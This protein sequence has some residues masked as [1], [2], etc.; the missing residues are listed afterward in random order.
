FIAGSNVT[1]YTAANATDDV[2]LTITVNDGG[3]NGI[4]GAQEDTTTV[5]LSVTPVNDAPVLADTDVVLVGVIEDAGQPSG[6]VGTLVTDL[7]GG[8]SDVDSDDAKGIAIVGVSDQGTLW[9]STNSSPNGGVWTEV[10]GVSESNALL[11]TANSQTRIYFQPN[12]DFSGTLSDA[13]TFRAWDGSAGINGEMADITAAGTG[14]GTPF[15]TA[16]D[17]AAIY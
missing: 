12:A 16:T 17:T 8:I 14:G 2:T 13:V 5:T 4:G 15:S 11:L 6:L 1:Y 7:V 9:V 10:I 3:R